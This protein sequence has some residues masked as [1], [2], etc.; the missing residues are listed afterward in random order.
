MAPQL[1]DP[2]Q[3]AEFSRE[4][5]S[6]WSVRIDVTRAIFKYCV[7]VKKMDFSC[8]FQV[9]SSLNYRNY[10]WNLTL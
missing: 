4:V 5:G 2:G 1:D 7:L 9:F 8:R 10:S 6:Q 3:W